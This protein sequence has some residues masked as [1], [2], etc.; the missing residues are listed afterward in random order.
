MPARV[1]FEITRGADLFL[2][3]KAEYGK[4]F[5]P[6]EVAMLLATGGVVKPVEHYVDKDPK[7]CWGSPK[8]T[9]RRW[10]MR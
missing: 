7:S 10:W 3:P 4:E 8:S 1:L 2:N 6:E 9:R 5:Y